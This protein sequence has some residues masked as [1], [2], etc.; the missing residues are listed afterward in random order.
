MDNVD[1]EKK[2]LKT[3]KEACDTGKEVVDIIK[4]AKSLG[5]I[6]GNA[7]LSDDEDGFII[8]NEQENE[9]L[10]QQTSRLI[11]INSNQSIEWKRFIIAHELGHYILHYDEKADRG[12]FAHRDH[13]K[14]KDEKEN[15]ADFFA[16]NLLMPRDRFIACYNSLNNSCISLDEKV[17][18]MANRFVVTDN[19]ARRRF[20]ELNLNE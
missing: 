9:I 16:A 15:E 12:M 18:L 11:G 8:V 4:V 17:L 20:K 5:F 1:I 19:M 7:E 14:G 13:K 6:V 2:A 10:G 3:L